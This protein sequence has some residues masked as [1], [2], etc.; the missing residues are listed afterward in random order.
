M[1]LGHSLR[2]V[3]TQ[4][5]LTVLI[6][7]GVPH[8]FRDLLRQV[9]DNIIVVK[10]LQSTDNGSTFFLNRPNLGT[11]YTKLHCWTL[12]DFSKAVFLDADIILC[13]Q[14]ADQKFVPSYASCI[15]VTVPKLRRWSP[16]IV[17]SLTG[18]RR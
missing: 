17:G 11:T 12:T 6:T 10:Q 7:E 8:S 14:R 9:Y 1:V 18:N 15:L 13:D 2:L 5:E 3:N 16:N 4:K